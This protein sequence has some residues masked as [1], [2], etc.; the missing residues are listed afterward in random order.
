MGKKQHKKDWAEYYDEKSILDELVA[1]SVDF[2]LDEVLLKEILSKGR[3]R[4]L[5]N[6]TIKIDPLHLR[7]IRKLATVKSIPYQTLVRHWLSEQIKKE[8]HLS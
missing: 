7:A 4:K 8:L 6:V 2:S 1:G 5:Q 3:K